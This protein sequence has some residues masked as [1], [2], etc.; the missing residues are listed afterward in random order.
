MI[1]SMI[2]SM[3]VREPS[4]EHTSKREYIV[5]NGSSVMTAMIGKRTNPSSYLH[6]G[7]QRETERGS[8]ID[9]A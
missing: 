6:G 2:A 1:A 7:A 9:C 5:N 8:R 4:H 3:M